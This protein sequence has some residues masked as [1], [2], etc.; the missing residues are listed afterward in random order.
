M[1]NSQLIKCKSNYAT[2]CTHY[3]FAPLYDSPYRTIDAFSGVMN[4]HLN[5]ML[6]Y[7]CKKDQKSR[8]IPA[9]MKN[10]KGRRSG[11]EFY[12]CENERVR[13]ESERI[14]EKL[15]KLFF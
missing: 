15:E 2:R 7:L 9:E 5:Q 11:G 6:N 10:S 4:F 8:I 13:M 14:N 3:L 12:E 1:S